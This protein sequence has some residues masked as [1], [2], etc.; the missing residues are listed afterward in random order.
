MDIKVQVMPTLKLGFCT[1]CRHDLNDSLETDLKLLEKKKADLGRLKA[2][3]KLVTQ[4]KT[5]E[6]W[7]LSSQVTKIPKV[8]NNTV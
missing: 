8:L 6:F 1:V 5:S 3:T 4:K 7:V 2:Q